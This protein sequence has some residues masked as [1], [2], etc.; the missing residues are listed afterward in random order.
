[1]T[2]TENQDRRLRRA[3]SVHGTAWHKVSGCLGD[4]TVHAARKRWI[5][6]GD[7]VQWAHGDI[8]TPA[9]LVAL[10][11]PKGQRLSWPPLV[12]VPSGFTL[13]G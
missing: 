10:A 11:L 3:V 9:P 1:M 2:W 6:I 4:V 8:A 12:R 13:R 5:Q 7:E